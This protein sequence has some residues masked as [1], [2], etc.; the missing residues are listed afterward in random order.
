[1][2]GMC[3]QMAIALIF[4]G[5]GSQYKGMGGEL[6]EGF[7]EAED[8]FREAD[9]TLGF[10]LQELCFEDR[11][12]ALNLTENSQ[13]ALLTV[14][15]AALK[16]L[17]RH[18]TI[19]TGFFAGHSLGEYSA[20]AAAGSIGFPDAL[21]LVRKRALLMKDASSKVN[22]GMCAIIGLDIKM[23]EEICSDT[24]G[25]VEIANI[26]SET[27]IVIS[28]ERGSLRKASE[29]AVS[30][31]AKKV[32]PLSVSGPFHSHFMKPAGEK[33]AEELAKIEIKPPSAPIISNVTARP[34]S[35]PR[36]IRENLTAQVSST[37]LWDDSI[38]FLLSSGVDTFIE[39]GPGRV[40]TKLIQRMGKNLRA[41]NI[42]DKKS[43]EKTLCLL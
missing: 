13:P 37:V 12:D 18:R 33:L 7:P 19:I 27:Q 36:E 11:Q 30:A 21:K 16:I 34:A 9:E 23:V 5:Q 24:H 32:I 3:N 4:P 10:K 29:Q 35:T 43:L 41:Y 22:G 2:G 31:G 17:E 38:K 25:G 39:L 26:N 28:G 8:I 42:E 6:V 15:I 14:S 40:L 1:M 20:L